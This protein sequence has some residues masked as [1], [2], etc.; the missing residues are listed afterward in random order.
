MIRRDAAGDWYRWAQR[1]I[2]P[3]QDERP[4][5]EA[6][7]LLVIHNIS[8]PAGKF[9]T[10]CVQKLFT[11]CL[12]AREYPELAE[13][14]KMKVSAHLLIERSGKLTQ[15]VPFNR[16]AWHAGK[17]RYA[18]RNNC[19]DFS[20]GIELEGTDTRPYTRK[21]YARLVAVTRALQR[22]YPDMS[23]QG[24]VGHSDIATPPG[25][26]SDPGGAF[27]WDFYRKSLHE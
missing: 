21:Q 23:Q 6:P 12:N 20:I 18:G 11:N 13:E 17:S 10:G 2:S 4:R 9:G 24:I 8:L 22:A 14:A 7:S 25:R 26:K 1:L 19:N 5:G 27:D 16:R 3:N 15:F